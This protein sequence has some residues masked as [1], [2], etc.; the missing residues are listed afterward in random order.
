MKTKFYLIISIIILL[1]GCSKDPIDGI[2]SKSGLN[3]KQSLDKWQAYRQSV[4]NNYTYTVTTVSW[5]GV[6]TETTITV[7]NGIV[8][9]RDYAEFQLA[10]SGHVPVKSWSETGTGLNTH[11]NEGAEIMTLDEVYNKA[12]SVWLRADPKANNI[13]FETENNGLISSCGYSPKNC[14]DDCF[15]GV[16]IKDIKGIQG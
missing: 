12:S 9:A 15:V 7:R 5:I 8:T 3:Y 13:Y 1:S 14:A 6:A 16:T 11:G 10:S 2:I 4:N